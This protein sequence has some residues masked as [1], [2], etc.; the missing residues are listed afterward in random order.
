MFRS[1]SRKAT[2]CEAPSR[3]VR[4]V[5]AMSS[6][7]TVATVTGGTSATD[8]HLTHAHPT[9]SLVGEQIESESSLMMESISDTATAKAV[10]LSTATGSIGVGNTNIPDA[11]PVEVPDDCGRGGHAGKLLV[12]G[13]PIMQ[14]GREGSTADASTDIV[15]NEGPSRLGRIDD[16]CRNPHPVD[17]S[18]NAV[19]DNEAGL[20]VRMATTSTNNTPPPQSPS[21]TTT[22]ATESLAPSSAFVNHGL[23]LW[24][25]KRK[26][27]LGHQEAN[28]MSPRKHAVPIDADDII[29][30]IFSASNGGA[31][32]F[33]LAVPLPQMVDILQDLWEAEGL[34]A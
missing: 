11:L 22:Q 29:E 1:L 24:E 6:E 34:D 7:L 13:E 12:V 2:T 26:E 23:L 33:P 25:T 31:R 32:Q 3:F 4:Y 14:E 17:P 15:T 16:E 30:V 9:P 8:E 28:R 10:S 27:W 20:M 21:R 18:A 5:G 19:D